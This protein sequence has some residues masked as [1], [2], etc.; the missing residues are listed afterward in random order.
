MAKAKRNVITDNCDWTK[1]AY[2]FT[3]KC[4]TDQRQQVVIAE[5]TMS[6]SKIMLKMTA[7]GLDAHEN[8]R[9]HWCTEAAMLIDRL[10]DFIFCTL[11]SACLDKFDWHVWWMFLCCVLSTTALLDKTQHRARNTTRITQFQRLTDS[12]GQTINQTK[13]VKI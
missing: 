6:K 11:S 4:S 5:N 9:R 8:Q 7:A 12:E 3:C 1:P 13:Y 10:V 2:P